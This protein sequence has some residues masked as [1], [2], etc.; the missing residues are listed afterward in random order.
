[1]KYILFLGVTTIIDSGTQRYAKKCDSVI[2]QTCISNK[3]GFL[4]RNIRQIQILVKFFQGRVTFWSPVHLVCAFLSILQMTNHVGF[5]VRWSTEFLVT[6]E[7]CEWFATLITKVQRKR[8]VIV[9]RCAWCFYTAWSLG[10]SYQ[11]YDLE[12]TGKC[13]LHKTDSNQIWK[14]YLVICWKQLARLK[15]QTVKWR[16]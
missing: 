14:S 13:S 11:V 5:Q 3:N 8:D 9:E 16:S 4:H 12:V 15:V 6:L 7:T 10:L 1:M 2:S